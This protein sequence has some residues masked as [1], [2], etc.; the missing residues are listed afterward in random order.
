MLHY[1]FIALIR[2]GCPDPFRSIYN[3]SSDPPDYT[4]VAN[5]N[6]E[7]A[8]MQMAQA[9]K[10]LEFSKQQYADLKPYVQA[11]LD[12]GLASANTQ[13]EIMKQNADYASAQRAKTDSMFDPV[14]AQMVK[15]AMD[16]G[17]E[18]DQSSLAQSAAANVDQQFD[19]QRGAMERGLTSMGVNPNSGKFVSSARTMDIAQA[20]QRAAQQTAARQTAKDKGIG[21]RAGAAN[22]GAGLGNASANAYNTAV[23]AGSAAAGAGSAGISGANQSAAGVSNAYNGYNGVANTMMQGNQM[24]MSGLNTAAGIDQA[25]A[26]GTNQLIGTSAGLGMI[27]L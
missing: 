27:A 8:E 5:A 12:Q 4:P 15:E 26:Q 14:K 10:S 22:Y 19:Q 2:M 1:N 16:Y 17:G 21:L 25:N 18:A 20:G 11:Q 23:G 24:M 13:N 9:D 3:E 6:K 7:V